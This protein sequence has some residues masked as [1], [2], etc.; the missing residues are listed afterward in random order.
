[1]ISTIKAKNIDQTLKDAQLD[2]ALKVANKIKRKYRLK[3]DKDAYAQELLSLDIDGAG[4]E[5]MDEWKQEAE[6]LMFRGNEEFDQII[7]LAKK[8]LNQKGEPIETLEFDPSTS[9]YVS[10]F[11][12]ELNKEIIK[13]YQQVLL[14]LQPCRLV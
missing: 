5:L 10:T 4:E 2:A 14:L 9:K 13:I 3:G 11:S 8:S 6:K 1:M 12:P 7:A